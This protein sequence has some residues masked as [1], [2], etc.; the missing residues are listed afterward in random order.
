KPRQSF[1]RV[2]TQG[3]ADWGCLVTEF[4]PS[5]SIVRR[6]PG[7]STARLSLVV[8]R[9]HSRALNRRS[10]LRNQ[11]FS[12]GSNRGSD[13]H[14]FLWKL[15]LRS[16]V[17]LYLASV[18]IG[19]GCLTR[20]LVLVQVLVRNN[21]QVLRAIRIGR[22]TRTSRAHLGTGWHHRLGHSVRQAL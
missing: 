4:V 10:R 21:Q 18:L 8:L 7:L 22:E 19:L 12:S 17:G 11:S 5:T 2:S 3:A 14:E 20:T 6:V 1:P 13:R 16:A 15:W 9:P